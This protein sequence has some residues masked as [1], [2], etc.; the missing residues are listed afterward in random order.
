[1]GYGQDTLNLGV[2]LPPEKAFVPAQDDGVPSPVTVPPPR[3]CAG[4]LL[5]DFAR[6]PGKRCIPQEQ[7]GEGEQQ[8][9]RKV[10]GGRRNAVGVGQ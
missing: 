5:F 1:M 9:E 8:N 3:D 6:K 10:L 2:P 4:T 7:Q